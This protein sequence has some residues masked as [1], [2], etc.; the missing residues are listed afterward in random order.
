MTWALHRAGSEVG[1]PGAVDAAEAGT[2]AD[3]GA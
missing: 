2:G 1:W 3:S